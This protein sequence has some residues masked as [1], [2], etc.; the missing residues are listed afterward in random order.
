MVSCLQHRLELFYYEKEWLGQ[1]VPQAR[2]YKIF[3]LS[4]LEKN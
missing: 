1:T 2:G 3:V 4:R